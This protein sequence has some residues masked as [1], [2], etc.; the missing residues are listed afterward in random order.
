[1]FVCLIRML[2]DLLQQVYNGLQDAVP[3]VRNAALFALGQFSEFLQ[4]WYIN[5]ITS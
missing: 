1:M 3:L 2:K 4:V 5:Y